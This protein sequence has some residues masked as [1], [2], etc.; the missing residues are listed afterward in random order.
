VLNKP[1]IEGLVARRDK[2]LEIFDQK[3]ARAGEAGVICDQPGH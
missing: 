2:I 1:E 3:I